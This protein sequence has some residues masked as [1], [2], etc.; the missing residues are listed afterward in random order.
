MDHRSSL[1]MS[2]QT[3]GCSIALTAA[4]SLARNAIMFTR[5]SLFASRIDAIYTSFTVIST[6]CGLKKPA[7]IASFLVLNTLPLSRP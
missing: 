7:V 6:L 2:G 5:G 4:W 1:L 3:L